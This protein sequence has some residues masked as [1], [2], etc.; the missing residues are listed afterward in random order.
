MKFSDYELF[1]VTGDVDPKRL[2]RFRDLLISESLKFQEITFPEEREP[3]FRQNMELLPVTDLGGFPLVVYTYSP[4]LI[5]DIRLR[6]AKTEKNSIEEK[7]FTEKVLFVIIDQG[8]I[9]YDTLSATGN[10]T[11]MKNH[12]ILSFLGDK[13][14]ECYYAG[15]DKRESPEYSEPGIILVEGDEPEPDNEP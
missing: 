5:L 9:S 2:V 15:L 7:W 14:S 1:I 8:H 6:A 11:S 3:L 12:W 4:A 13:E 10:F